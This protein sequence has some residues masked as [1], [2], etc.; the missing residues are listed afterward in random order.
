M[1]WKSL[2]LIMC[3]VIVGGCS[4]AGS[5]PS[6]KDSMEEFTKGEAPKESTTTAP[7]AGKDGEPAGQSVRGR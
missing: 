7:E 4:N 6:G 5:A 3:L 2:L 1:N